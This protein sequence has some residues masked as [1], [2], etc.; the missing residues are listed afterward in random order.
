M[1][2]IIGHRGHPARHPENILAAVDAAIVAGAD[3]V[4][5]GSWLTC[6]GAVVCS[7]EPDLSSIAGHSLSAAL[8]L[9]ELPAHIAGRCNRC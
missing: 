5:T 2:L 7:L 8:L 1:T 6:D 9:G 4:V 3:A